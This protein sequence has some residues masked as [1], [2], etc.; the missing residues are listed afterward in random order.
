MDTVVDVA[1]AIGAG[2]AVVAAVVVVARVGRSS[3]LVRARLLWVAWGVLTT[4]AVAVVGLALSLLLD[5]P[6]SPDAGLAAG[7]VLVP[8][9][10]LVGRSARAAQAAEPVLVHTLVISGLAGM[11]GGIY[12]LVVLGLGRAP[13]GEE[14][15]VLALS[16]AAAAVVS[17]LALPVRRR[18]EGW[19]NQRVY[20][21]RHPRRGAAHLRRTHVARRAARR[22]APAAGRD[23][24][25]DHG[26]VVRG[27][28][29]RHRR[30][31]D[32]HGVGAGPADRRRFGSDPEELPVAARAHAQGNAW[33]AV[34]APTL[35]DGRGDGLVRSVSVAHL[36]E[37]LGMIVIDRP[38]GEAPFSEEEDRVLSTWPARSV[39]PCTTSAS[40]RRCRPASRSSSGATRSWWRPGP[41]SS[42]RPTRS[43][44]RIE[45]NLHDGAQQ[46]LVA[47]AVK[48]GL[49]QAAARERPG[50][51]AWGCWTSSAVTCRPRSRSCGSWRT[52]STRRC[53]ATGAW[54]RR[55]PAGHRVPLPTATVMG[56]VGRYDTEVETAIYFCCLEAMQNAGKHAGGRRHGSRWRGQRR[57][58]AV[59]RGGRR[60]RRIRT[61]RRVGEPRLRQH[62]GPPRCGRRRADRHLGAGPRAPP[63]EARCP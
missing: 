39:S 7:C 24:Q 56:E 9:A 52:A 40:T 45:R 18:L 10:L 22:A 59:V 5:W 8:A 37:L 15:G 19:A 35:L 30:G 36:G 57:R 33:L 20:G 61:G 29:D 4:A 26:A 50:H 6:S 43:R 58:L 34:W 2:L 48:V 3:G 55:S 1:A 62:A 23:A 49:D 31:A 44:R 41:A 60:R 16:M 13:E 63:C 27:D 46:H 42:R 32:P 53:S 38:D 25:E 14:R 54:P 28:L 47:L 51:G 17:V 11:A 12:V 21:E